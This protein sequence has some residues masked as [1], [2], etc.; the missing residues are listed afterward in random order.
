MPFTVATR[1]SGTLPR[2]FDVYVRLLESRG[3]DWTRAPRLPAPGVR[4]RWLYVWSNRREAEAF[5]DELRKETRNDAWFVRELSPSVQPSTGPL[6]TVTVLM[7]RNRLG[8]EFALHP[9][10]RVLIRRRFPWAKSVFS[11][12]IEADSRSDFERESSP[13]WEHVAQML[14][15][16]SSSELSQLGGYVVIDSAQDTMVVEGDVAVSA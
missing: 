15:G 9:H 10:S 5:C 2:E 7:G 4:N 8:A 6:I 11:V 16:L 12:A 1:E 3:I 13:I 14:T